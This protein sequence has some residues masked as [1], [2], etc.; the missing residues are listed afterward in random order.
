MANIT[1]INSNLSVYVDH[2][3]QDS[4]NSHH[5]ECVDDWYCASA[6]RKGVAYG[7]RTESDEFKEWKTRCQ[8]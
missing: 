4:Q 3:V 8:G 5:Q 1:T 6:S 2:N 7:F